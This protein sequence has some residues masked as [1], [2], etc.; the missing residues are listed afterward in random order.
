MNETA[1]AGNIY[2]RSPHTHKHVHTHLCVR[3]GFSHAHVKC[4]QCSVIIII[5]TTRQENNTSSLHKAKLSSYGCRMQKRG[6][7]VGWVGG[8]ESE[9]GGWGEGV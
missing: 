2:V 6:A 3:A 9:G 4:C 7:L 5:K 1:K 8:W